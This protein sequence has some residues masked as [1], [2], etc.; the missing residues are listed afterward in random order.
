MHRKYK[1]TETIG[2]FKGEVFEKLA[3]ENPKKMIL[4]K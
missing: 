1:N 4:N 3:V 2:Q